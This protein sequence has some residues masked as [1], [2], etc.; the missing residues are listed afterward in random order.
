MCTPAPQHMCRGQRTTFRESV[1]SLR[2]DVAS[3]D[4]TQLLRPGQQAHFTHQAT[5]PAPPYK[6]LRHYLSCNLKVT[7]LVSIGWP[8]DFGNL[9]VSVL[10]V[11]QGWNHSHASPCYLRIWIWGMQAQVLLLVW[12]VP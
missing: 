11:S 2:L 10:V 4:G 1:F 9:P 12:Q 7:E 6:L 8:M 3:R 5:S